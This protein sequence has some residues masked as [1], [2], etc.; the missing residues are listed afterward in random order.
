M[1]W[2]LTPKAG[3]PGHIEPADVEEA[4]ALAGLKS[5]KTLNASPDWV[6]SRMVVA[7]R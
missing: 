5:T 7:R 4:V 3:R 6:A 2:L 1:V